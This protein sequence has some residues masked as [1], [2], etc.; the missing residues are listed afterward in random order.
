MEKIIDGLGTI[1]YDVADDPILEEFKH[2][3][4]VSEVFVVTGVNDSTDAKG[5]LEKFITGADYPVI[6]KIKKE[7]N[8]QSLIMLGACMFLPVLCLDFVY[9][10]TDALY[11]I[12]VTNEGLKAY[13]KLQQ[14]AAGMHIY[15]V[16]N[17]KEGFERVFGDLK[18][19]F[20]KENWE[21]L[22]KYATG[23]SK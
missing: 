11:F 8:K 23:F 15:E 20:S 2:A 19:S 21:S 22:Q 7:M 16:M 18:G 14:H 4:G 5:A 12:G 3:T 6:L 13:Q 9:D 1:T 17:D 10:D